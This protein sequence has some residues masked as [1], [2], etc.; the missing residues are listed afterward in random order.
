[1]SKTQLIEA[2][3]EKAGLTKADASRA[4]EAT[5]EAIV[6]ALKAGEKVTLVGFGTFEAKKKPA[7]T[8]RNPRTGENVEV[9]ARIAPTFKA[10][11]KFKDALN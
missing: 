8:C 7:R 9:A 2:I 5:T 1:M 11:S 10:G 6:K 3:A 4:L